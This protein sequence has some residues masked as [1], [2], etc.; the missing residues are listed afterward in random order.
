VS[1][2]LLELAKLTS[3]NGLNKNCCPLF[4]LG[5]INV[6]GSNCLRESVI[7]LTQ[8]NMRVLCKLMTYLDDI[9]VCIFII[10]E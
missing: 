9:Y 5:V 8:L 1:F 10:D 6:L 3:T 2:D 7:S 4:S